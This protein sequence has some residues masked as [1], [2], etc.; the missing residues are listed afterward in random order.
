MP[1]NKN[2]L[3]RYQTMDRCF[4]NRGREY[5]IEDLME[6]CNMALEEFTGAGASISRRQVF[7]DI[8]YMESE[9]GWAIPLEKHKDGKRTFYRYSDLE[10]SINKRPLNESEAEQLKEA[11]L[12]LSRFKGMPQFEWVDELVAR[13]EAGFG[14]K[15]GAAQVIEF[16][17]NPYLKGAE[18]ITTLFHSIINEQALEISYQGFKQNAPSIVLLHPYYLKQYNNR[19]FV[20]GLEEEGR[21]VNMALDRIRDIVPSKVKYIPNDEVDFTE[22]F[23]DVVG[24]SVPADQ[25]AVVVKIQVTDRLWPYLESK[26]I[27]GSQKVVKRKDGGATIRL[28][29]KLNYELQALLLSYGE[30]LQVI[31]PEELRLSLIHISEPTRPY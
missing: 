7:E 17:Q 3:I 13:L 27:H 12:T 5:F 24:V 25:E 1:V 26:P 31:A 8:K 18:H 22:Y 28:E 19:W 16:E 23:E 21:I 14:L 29:V 4:A 15:Q 9:Q 2:A 10:F 11:L 6:A 30:G 20:F